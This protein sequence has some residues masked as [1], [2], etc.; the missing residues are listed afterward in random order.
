M[1]YLGTYDGWYSVRDE[2]F[3]TEAE[4]VDGKAPTGAEVEWVQEESYFFRLSALQDRLLEHYEKHPEFIGPD[5]RRNEVVKFVSGGLRDLSVSRASFSWGV[6]VPNDEKHVMYVWMDALTNYISTLGYPD[7][8]NFAKFWPS[9]IH[10]VG[11][12]IVRFHAVYWPAFLMAAD[13]PVPER[14]FAHGWWTKDGQKISKSIGNV[15]DP[16]DLVEKYGVDAT[17]FFLMSEVSFGSDGDYSDLALI[18]RVNANLANELGNLCQRTLSLVFKNCDKQLPAPNEL[19]EQDEELLKQARGLYD[20]AKPLMEKQAINRYIT[21]PLV[22]M[23]VEANKYIDK[24]EPW[25]LKKTD[26]ER[27]KTVLYV[28]LETLRYA[29]ILYQ[30]VIPS[31]A[32]KILDAITVPADEREFRHLTDEFKLRPGSEIA[33]PQGVFPRLEVPETVAA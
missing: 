31:S 19:L 30:P 32:G 1:I 22:N 8:D 26:P 9:S 20:E 24:E 17:R 14:V 27:M 29:T 4:L 3:Y 16:L 10:I 21:Q 5:G 33:K 11:K 6:P 2:C 28:I 12:D 18:Y 23:I 25:V 7:G 15:I 13:L